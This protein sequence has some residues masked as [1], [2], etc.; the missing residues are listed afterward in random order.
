MTINKFYMIFM[1]Y[2]SLPLLSGLL[3]ALALTSYMT[4]LITITEHVSGKFHDS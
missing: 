4:R 1:V 2:G 3:T